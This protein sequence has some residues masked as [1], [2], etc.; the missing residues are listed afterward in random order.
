MHCPTV[1]EDRCLKL[2][3][4]QGHVLSEN[5]RGGAFLASSWILVVVS[6]PRHSLAQTCITPIS[7]CLHMVFSSV[8]VFISPLF[9]RTPVILEQGHPTPVL[10][11]LNLIVSAKKKKKPIWKQGRIHRYWGLGL[12]IPFWVNSQNKYSPYC[13]LL[14]C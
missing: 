10:S 4:Q 6:H 3:C 14:L 7:L 9:I 2:T 13:C 8:R 1:L 12:H 11:H 5:L